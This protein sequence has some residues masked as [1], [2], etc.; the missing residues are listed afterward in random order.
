M[1]K[2]ETPILFLIFNRPET[3]KIVFEEIK[4]AKPPRLYIASDG[5]RETKKEEL[6]I[7]NSLRNYIVNNIDW[8]CE[9]KTLFRENNLGCKEAVKGSIDW[10]FE[11]EEMGIILEDDCLPSFSFFKFC[12]E[13][14]IKYKDDIR[15]SGVCGNNFNSKL[16]RNNED[17]YFYSEI[18]Y[19]WGW[20]TWRKS[21]QNNQ[22]FEK[23]FNNLYENKEFENIISNSKA[24]EM[25]ISESYNAI[26]GIIDTWDYQWLFSNVCNNKLAVIPK[27]N[28]VL[29]I[30]FDENATHTKHIRKELIVKNGELDFPLKNP[31]IITRNF[32]YDDFFYEIIY[33]WVKLPKRILNKIKKTFCSI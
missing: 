33:G 20:G 22:D 9:I 16:N 5:A 14:L 31:K 3:T 15:I 21:W 1:F 30:G 25:W 7:V 23:K 2:N 4:A 12:Q 28:L 32:K 6:E 29:N 10:F 17:S 19:M 18:L 27:T 24:N 13:V 8:D 11:N 26:N